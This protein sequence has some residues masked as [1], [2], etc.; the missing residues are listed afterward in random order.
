MARTSV[1]VDGFNLYHGL[2][3]L[4]TTHEGAVSWKWLDPRALSGRV[5]PNDDICHVR[6]FTARL[7]ADGNGPDVLQRQQTYIRALE[8]LP[9]VTVHFGQFMAQ[10]KRMPLAERPGRLQRA[11]LR[12]VGVGPKFHPDGNV[13]VNVWRMEEKGSDVNLASYLLLD[14]F[15]GEFEKALVFSNDTDLCE[16]VRIVV[17]EFGLTVV[18]VNPRGHKQPAVALRKVAS[19]TRG[20]R[21]SAVE[22]SQL[23]TTLADARGV[24]TKPAGW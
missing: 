2:K 7:S 6:Y 4:A 22:A 10:K 21:L 15:R 14:A 24:I 19:S 8:S 12:R 18:V 13:T 3:E 16:P 11:L 20:V 17:E 1:Y 9:D 23:P 5:A